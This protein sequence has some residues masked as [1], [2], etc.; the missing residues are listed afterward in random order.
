V[1]RDF[2]WAAGFGILA[3]LNKSQRPGPVDWR[4]IIGGQQSILIG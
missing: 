3:R 1:N 4:Q 2:Y